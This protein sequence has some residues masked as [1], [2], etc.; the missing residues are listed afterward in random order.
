[1]ERT[2]LTWK[3]TTKTGREI[4]WQAWP[5]AQDG[6]EFWEV[7]Q[8]R[9]VEVDGALELESYGPDRLLSNEGLAKL[10]RRQGVA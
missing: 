6:E 7:L 2:P 1:M 10:L 9:V 4:S 8:V 5:E 3:T